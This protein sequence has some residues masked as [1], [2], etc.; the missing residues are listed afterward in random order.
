MDEKNFD[1]KEPYDL[2]FGYAVEFFKR[3][4]E[5]PITVC[6]FSEEQY[7]RIALVYATYLF[8]RLIRKEPIDDF[9]ATNVFHA[10]EYIVN[11]I[12]RPFS[13]VEDLVRDIL[14]KISTAK[15]VEGLTEFVDEKKKKIFC[16]EQKIKEVRT[17]LSE[18][19][20]QFGYNEVNNDAGLTVM[21]NMLF[22][23]TKAVMEEVD[24]II[25]DP[26]NVLNYASAIFAFK[27]VNDMDKQMEQMCRSNVR[28]KFLS[29]LM[30]LQDAET[31]FHIGFYVEPRRALEN[32]LNI[33]CNK[34][35]L[36]AVIDAG[37]MFNIT[38]EGLEELAKL[39]Y[40][41]TGNADML[42]LTLT[43]QR[44][45]TEGW[46]AISEDEVENLGNFIKSSSAKNGADSKDYDPFSRIIDNLIS[47][48]KSYK[49]SYKAMYVEAILKLSG[50][51]FSLDTS[52]LISENST[53]L[54]LSNKEAVNVLREFFERSKN[55]PCDYIVAALSLFG[56]V[57]RRFFSFNISEGEYYL[58]GR[59]DREENN[60]Q[61]YQ[62]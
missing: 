26:L 8:E 15:S 33:Y 49:L 34:G 4:H 41:E 29:P 24:K 62:E 53:I 54:D 42:Q 11:S 55:E 37:S 10:V 13:I 40:D 7:S 31:G 39:F 22:Y 45:N 50:T 60:N 2:I 25:G 59:T 28:K 5:E 18:G 52:E 19:C 38:M 47:Q 61:G 32:V 46:N 1:P 12:N 6:S 27:D 14:Y 57:M 44:L 9:R 35:I 48:Q 30:M 36:P 51:P 23:D 21:A 56:Q 16:I 3:S 43:A 17:F 20:E 58:E